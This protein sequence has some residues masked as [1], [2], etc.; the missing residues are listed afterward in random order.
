MLYKCVAEQD[1][2]CRAGTEGRKAVDGE[3]DEGAHVGLCG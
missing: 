1:S 2:G 3:S